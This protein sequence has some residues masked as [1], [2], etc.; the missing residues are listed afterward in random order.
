MAPNDIKRVM[1]ATFHDRLGER[2]PVSANR[3]LALLSHVM[4]FAC[5]IGAA[6]QNP[7][8]GVERHT[9]RERRRYISDAEYLAVHGRATPVMRVLMDLAYLT[10]QRQGDI[11]KLTYRQFET[12]GIAFEQ[13]KTGR[14]LIVRWS[15]ALHGVIAQARELSRIDSLYVVCTA[16]GQPYTLS[17]LRTAWQRLMRGCMDAGA[18]SERFTFHDIRAKAGSDAKD[19]RLLGHLDERTLRRIYQR[20]PEHFDPVR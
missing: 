17:G 13:A 5:R 4:K 19:G 10:G 20:K 7:C 3:H 9:E 14:K 16:H 6:E 18:L 8:K 15:D 1:V 12:D 11:V 2:S